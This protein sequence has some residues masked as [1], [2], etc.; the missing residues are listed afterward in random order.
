MFI[1]QT[2]RYDGNSPGNKLTMNIDKTLAQLRVEA[3]G[4]AGEVDC[5]R[6]ELRR[7]NDGL[8]RVGGA[9]RELEQKAQQL[10]SSINL[11]CQQ[12]DK[13]QQQQALISEKL[14]SS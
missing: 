4:L 1:N 5:L 14:T 10:T 2:F 6:H 13:N 8:E 3:L 7:V 11:C 9:S 12:L